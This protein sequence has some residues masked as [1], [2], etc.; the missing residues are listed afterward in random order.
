MKEFAP[1]RGSLYQGQRS[2]LLYAQLMGSK[3]CNSNPKTAG[4]ESVH[5]VLVQHGL[6]NCTGSIGQISAL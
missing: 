4:Q 1:L 3:S 5:V 6:L 2:S